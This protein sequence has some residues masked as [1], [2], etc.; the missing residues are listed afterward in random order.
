LTDFTPEQEEQF[1]ALLAQRNAAVF[2]K[3]SPLDEILN[4]SSYLAIVTDL[5]T[6]LETLDAGEVKDKATVV[7]DAMLFVAADAQK[8]INVYKPV[9]QPEPEAPAPQSEAPPSVDEQQQPGPND[10]AGDQDQN[11][12]VSPPPAEPSADPEP[13]IE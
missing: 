5:T 12:D 7:R 3:L 11:M 6:V 13:P 1:Q 10:Q 9:A 4:R 8:I 2:V